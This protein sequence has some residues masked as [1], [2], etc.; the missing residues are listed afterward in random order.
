MLKVLLEDDLPDFS[1]IEP[2][3]ILGHSDYHPPVSR[4]LGH[5]IVIDNVDPPSAVLG[6]EAF[7][8]RIYNA[9]KAMQ[10]STGPDV[11]DTALLIGWD[12]PGGTYDHV[13]P[14]PVP[15]LDPAAPAG[16][17]GFKFDRSGYR[18]PAI[19]VSPWVAPG[20]VYNEEY[21]HTSL[22]ARLRE[23]WA[24]GG[25]S[26]AGTPLPAHSPRSSRVKPR[27]TRRLGLR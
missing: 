17:F 7:L 27:W 20:S 13:P 22:I 23:Q 24:L 3:L 21:R 6:G 1:F 15:P 26:T 25:P 11:W 19:L 12:E 16:E 2:C 18:V 5:G 9:Y 8:S 4:A 14:G 10:S